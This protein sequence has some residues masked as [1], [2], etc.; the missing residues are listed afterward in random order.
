MLEHQV[1]QSIWGEIHKTLVFLQV[2][3]TISSSFITI[4]LI[5]LSFV[6]LLALLGFEGLVEGLILG[7]FQRQ[8]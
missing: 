2:K 4:S 5:S 1:H 6:P 8:F 7:G 3:L